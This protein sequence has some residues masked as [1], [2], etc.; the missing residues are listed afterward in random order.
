MK[1]LLSFIL[2]LLA[3]LPATAQDSIYNSIL[4]RWQRE[5]QFN[6][7]VLVARDGRLVWTGAAGL[8]DRESKKQL[9]TT[10]PF[11]IAALTKAFTAVMILQ[12]QEEGLLRV[13]D[14]IGKYLPAYKGPGRNEVT[15]YQLLTYSSGIPD[16]QGTPGTSIYRT[17]IPVDT[18][19]ARYCS[20]PLAYRP[21]TRSQYS[22]G[23]YILL[24]KIIENVT[25]R[26]YTDNLE[27]RILRPLRMNATGPLDD[28][29]P[30]YGLARPY[31]YKDSATGLLPDAPYITGNYFGAGSLYS[32]VFDLM[33]FDAALFG[34]QLLRA[35]TLKQMLRGDEKLG[36]MALGVW[37]TR[38]QGGINQPYVYRS[39]NIGGSRANWIHVLDGNLS[40]IV[41]SNTDRGDLLALTRELYE[42]AN[43][44]PA[45]R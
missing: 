41:L 38:G 32:T 13:D 2:I 3:A 9:R 8:A 22:N 11:R 12:L 31:S 33:R 17:A 14:T 1:P 45:R 37:Y 43:K 36:N 7:T 4:Q 5:H 29:K 42:A 34:Q 16:C 10:T 23:D 25:G 35:G 20:G 24:G 39:A 21:G 18:F 15:L 19:I 30:V 26:T 28:A 6:G 27:R 40:V 44:A